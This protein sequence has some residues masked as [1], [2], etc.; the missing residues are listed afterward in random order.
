MRTFLGLAALV[1][2]G[3]AS[4]QTAQASSCC[5]GGFSPSTP[6]IPT[7]TGPI[8][9]YLP[10][11][12]P[13]QESGAEAV[14]PRAVIPPVPLAGLISDARPV[15]DFD[16]VNPVQSFAG[17]A[18]GNTMLMFLADGAVSFWNMNQGREVKRISSD[19]GGEVLAAAAAEDVPLAVSASGS[20][21]LNFWSL[22][23]LEG[24]VSIRVDGD[25]RAEA[26]AMSRDGTLA[27]A[28]FSDGSVRVFDA[29][30]RELLRLPGGASAITAMAFSSDKASLVTADAGGEA[31][32]WNAAAGTL[33]KST[34][35]S[36]VPLQSLDL[37]AGKA[38]LTDANGGVRTW[39][40][41]DQVRDVPTGGGGASAT[42]LS[43]DG[44]TLAVARKDGSVQVIDAATGGARFT[45]PGG[46]PIRSVSFGKGGS[47]LFLLLEDGTLRVVQA[48]N[49]AEVVRLVVA[50]EGWVAISP[51]GQFDGEGDGIDAAK[52]VAAN[53]NASFALE[54][55]T[56]SSFEPGLLPRVAEEQPPPAT[57]VVSKAF[58]VPPVVTLDGLREGATLD[59]DTATVNVAVADQGGGISEVR[60]YLNDKLVSQQK[61][62]PGATTFPLS[63]PVSLTEG[64]NAISAVALSRENIE[65]K[66]AVV[67]VTRPGSVRLGAMRLMT[68]GINE[69]A[70][71]ELSLEYGVPDS[72]GIDAFFR[73][74]PSTI[75]TKVAPSPLRNRQATKQ[76]ILNAFTSLAETAPEDT[77][78]VYLAG[79][80]EAVES[81]WYFIPHDITYPLKRS[82]ITAGGLSMGDVSA[83][84]ARTKAQKVVLLLDA[85]KSGAALT[86][87]RNFE[88]RKEWTKMARLAGVHII[89][90]AGKDQYAAEVPDLGH[91]AFTYTLLKGL[92]GEAAQSGKITVAQLGSYVKEKLPSLVAKYADE[93][94]VPVV[95]SRGSDFVLG[96][97]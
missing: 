75:F 30:G 8:V 74:V 61:V 59:Q 22:N 35:I 50:S 60:V 85:C 10:S 62:P 33:V 77:V 25:A 34:R 82:D 57:V 53:G 95:Y 16:R 92:Q 14:R 42:A 7:V 52:W 23:K 94:Q 6:I 55:F 56:E 88:A 54:Q 27:A 69:Y 3:M 15:F 39:N 49:G 31:R 38:F 29:A 63:I 86:D 37:I 36:S 9:P 46:M 51:K 26:V 73:A 90:A 17:A 58:G 78:L 28:G 2:A 89:A 40:L 76:G 81:K 20:G 96:G 68:V 45:I 48:T 5:G 41:A 47:L 32:V 72:D 24:L 87:V 84:V 79:H 91:G 67:H 18:K 97:R 71:K 80:G 21:S 13:S 66:T 65:G 93:P 64:R 19:D 4:V 70:H 44:R 43:Q 1:V 83:V 11:S 12:D